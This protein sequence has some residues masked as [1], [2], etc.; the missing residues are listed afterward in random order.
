MYN[1][2]DKK[3]FSQIYY[4]VISITVRISE[5]M[6][7]VCLDNIQ[8]MACRGSNEICKT[9]GVVGIGLIPIETNPTAK[10]NPKFRL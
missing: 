7:P 8:V 4:I 5:A 1:K 2:T 10:S 6:W 3:N 9:L